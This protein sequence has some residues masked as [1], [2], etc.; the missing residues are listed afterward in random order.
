MKINAA[1]DVLQYSCNAQN[2]SASQIQFAMQLFEQ[3][4]SKQ[5]INDICIIAANDA[6]VAFAMELYP[7][8]NNSMHHVICDRANIFKHLPV[9]SE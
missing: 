7:N 4:H 5:N 1:K 6:L 2:I 8:N 3:M 9:N